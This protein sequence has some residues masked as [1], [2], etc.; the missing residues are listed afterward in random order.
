MQAVFSPTQRKTLRENA[1]YRYVGAIK[2]ND[3]VL[4][5]YKMSILILFNNT[6]LQLVFSQ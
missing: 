3:M 2:K 6:Q 5:C 1:T 4:Q